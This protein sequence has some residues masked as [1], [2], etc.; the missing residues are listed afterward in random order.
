MVNLAKVDKMVNNQLR[1]S[2]S[3][4][5][6]GALTVTDKH[7]EPSEIPYI[8]EQYIG[9]SDIHQELAVRNL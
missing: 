7:L 5:D 3:Q 2:Q 6:M 8:K 9:G 1:L 4:R